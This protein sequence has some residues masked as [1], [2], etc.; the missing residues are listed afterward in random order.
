MIERGVVSEDQFETIYTSETFPTTGYGTVYNLHPTCRRR[1]GGLLQLRLG[2]HGAGG[3]S[4]ASRARRSSSRSPS[5]RLVGDPQID[6]AM[7][8]SYTCN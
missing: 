1:S 3:R 5:R 4:S 8:V 6:A 7:G 2:R